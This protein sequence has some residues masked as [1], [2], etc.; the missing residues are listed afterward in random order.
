MDK[1][2]ALL[3]ISEDSSIS[4]IEIAYEKQLKKY[5]SDMYAED[6]A[7]SKKRCREVKKAYDAIMLYR[8]RGI[9]PKEVKHCSVEKAIESTELEQSKVTEPMKPKEKLVIETPRADARLR[10]I[11]K[12]KK[13]AT[14][15]FLW[16]IIGLILFFS[17]LPKT[18]EY[19]PS[20]FV[21]ISDYPAPEVSDIYVAEVVLAANKFIEDYAEDYPRESVNFSSREKGSREQTRWETKFTKTYWNKQNFERVT[22]YLAYTYDG[23]NCDSSYSYI[24]YYSAVY[25]FYGFLSPEEL[26]GYRNPFSKAVID[27]ALDMYKY[28]VTFYEEYNKGNVLSNSVAL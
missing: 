22:D 11:E 18:P 13:V 1:Y 7:Y 17:I 12:S 20:D 15:G 24:S 2:F 27:S 16:G 21:R 8:R 3:G 26:L 4:E 25:T 6:P 5:K 19:N 28:Y 10:E 23:Y 9:L 14:F